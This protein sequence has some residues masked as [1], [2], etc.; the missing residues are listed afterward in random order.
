[1]D[2]TLAVLDDIILKDYFYSAC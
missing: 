2:L 1:M